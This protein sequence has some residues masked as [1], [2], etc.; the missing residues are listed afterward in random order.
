MTLLQDQT[1]LSE[2]NIEPR[3]IGGML[4]LS[5]LNFS[6]NNQP[7]FIN[8]QSILLNNASSGLFLVI[9]FLNPNQVWIPSY[10]CSS[11]V[12]TLNYAKANI[13]FYEVNYDLNIINWDWLSQIKKDD[14][15]ILIDYFGWPINHVLATE[16][17]NKGG[18]VLED[19]SQALL[20]QNINKNS[21]FLLFS[22]RKFLGIP[23]GGI[24]NCN[25]QF[26]FEQ[27]ELQSPPKD[28]WLKSLSATILRREFDIYGGERHW[29]HLF[30]ETELNY[31][32]GYY[33]MSELS[34]IL[35]EFSFNYEQISQKRVQNYQIF[36]E[37][38]ADIALFKQLSSG[39]IPLGFPIR[40]Q[41]RDSLRQLLFSQEIYPPIHWL[42][43]DIVPEKFKDSHRLSREIMTLPCDQRY[44]EDAMEKI[45]N[46]VVNFL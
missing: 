31:P 23:D 35:L 15:V 30:Q 40:I 9:K 18:L 2:E 42:I 14:L 11:I 6:T 45:A 7:F 41:N 24:L 44:N 21:D 28:W 17:K 46:L 3:I 5:S 37:K 34:Q 10:L 25:Y 32:I 8:N 29:Y 20:S 16:I 22:P 38:L 4:G 27:I 19:A 43:E 26:D 1:W 33:G 13:I 39:V 12:K 36:Q